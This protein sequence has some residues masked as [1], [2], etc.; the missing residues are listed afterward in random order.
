MN[1]LMPGFGSPSAITNPNS[2]MKTQPSPESPQPSATKGAKHTPTPALP[3]L[4]WT[5]DVRSGL[6]YI[7]RDDK[8]GT[9]IATVMLS[10]YYKGDPSQEE[11]AIGLVDAWNAYASPHSDQQKIAALRG[12]LEAC[13]SRLVELHF[14]T[15]HCSGAQIRQAD[16]A[17]AA[18]DSPNKEGEAGE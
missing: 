7:R 15:D 3:R 9:H 12:A 10:G 8:N 16:A 4:Y 6:H 14:N 1:T 18:L 11:Y 13:R 5:K 17:L 2:P